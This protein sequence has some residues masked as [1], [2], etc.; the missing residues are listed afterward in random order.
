MKTRNAF[1]CFFLHQVE[2]QL[3][4]FIAYLKGREGEESKIS[5]F[6]SNMMS[7]NFQTSINQWV[8]GGEKRKWPGVSYPERLQ[9][10]AEPGSPGG[11]L[12]SQSSHLGA[13]HL[14]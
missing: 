3:L 9:N 14:H 11:D 8:R 4:L 5:F 12:T 2:C 10:P 6:F 13:K 1:E 7:H